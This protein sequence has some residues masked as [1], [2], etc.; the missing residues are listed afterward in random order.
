MYAQVRDAIAR[1]EQCDKVR[2]SISFQQLTLSPLPIQGLLYHWS[3][4]LNGQLS[5]TSRGN[6]Y[7]MIMIEQFFKVGRTCCV[8]GQVITQ[9]QPSF[10]TTS[11]K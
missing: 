3:C 8:V 5:Q 6:V 11:L 9:H 1:C 4:D 10:L 2:T 7:I